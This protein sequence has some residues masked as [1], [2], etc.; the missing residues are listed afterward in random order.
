MQS[1]S[2]CFPVMVCT[3]KSIQVQSCISDTTE[4][5]GSD[6]TSRER[7]DRK[8]TEEEPSRRLQGPMRTFHIECRQEEKALRSAN[9]LRQLVIGIHY[10]TFGVWFK[11]HVER[12]H[13]F[14]HFLRLKHKAKYD[15]THIFDS[16]RHE[17]LF[18]K[19]TKLTKVMW[20]W[21]DSGKIVYYWKRRNQRRHQS[22]PW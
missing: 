6:A 11:R 13:P 22:I 16:F 4:P 20:L 15:G 8:I 14:Q 17:V 10:L 3:P 21:D 1:H 12:H 5:K 19:F 9:A 18:I 2:I 7:E